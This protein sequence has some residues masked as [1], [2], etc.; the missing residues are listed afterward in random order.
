MRSFLMALV[1]VCTISSLAMASPVGGS[2]C[3]YERV[4][5]GTTDRF[6]VNFYGGDV[7]KVSISGDGDTDLD[8]YIYDSNGNLLAQG[9]SSSDDEEVYFVAPWNGRVTILVQNRGGVYNN[10]MICAG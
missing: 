7:A 10:Y 3:D 9:V 5:A 2:A 8:L 6:E 1:A 4:L